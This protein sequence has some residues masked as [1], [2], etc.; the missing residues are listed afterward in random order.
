MNSYYIRYHYTE[1]LHD[2]I[3]AIVRDKIHAVEFIEWSNVN[4]D[5]VKAVIKIMTDLED[6]EAV[7]ISLIQGTHLEKVTISN[8]ESQTS[9]SDLDFYLQNLRKNPA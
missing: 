8:S 1:E 5:E 2:R 7:F 4:S 9:I 3:A 6:D